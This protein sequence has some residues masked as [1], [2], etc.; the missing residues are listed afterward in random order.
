MATPTSGRW[1]SI[2][3]DNGAAAAGITANSMSTAAAPVGVDGPHVEADRKRGIE[4]HH[5]ADRDDGLDGVVHGEWCEGRQYCC[6]NQ[7]DGILHRP[8]RA[9]VDARTVPLLVHAASRKTQQR[10]DK[11]RDDWVDAM[12]AH[13]PLGARGE[14]RDDAENQRGYPQ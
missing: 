1:P 6:R 10:N 3:H 11:Q 5:A 9:E 12:G 8:H 13:Q 14:H 4:Q 2:S 7:R